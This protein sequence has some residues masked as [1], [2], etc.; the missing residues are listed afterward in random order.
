VVVALHLEG[1]G[2][3]LAEV[4][5]ARVLAGALEDA[6]PARRKAAQE[7]GRVLVGAMLRPEQREDGELEVVRLPAEE[8][9][10]TVELAVGQPEG[11][12]QRLFRDRSQVVQSS[13]ASGAL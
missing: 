2:L 12:V 6:R 13:A 7:P 10:D 3:A 9:L 5:D 4:D 1:D 11:T 8:L